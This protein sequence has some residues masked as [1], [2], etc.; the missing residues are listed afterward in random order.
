MFKRCGKTIDV[1]DSEWNGDIV[2]V[3]PEMTEEAGLQVYVGVYGVSEDGKRITPT[4]YAPLGAV[5]LGAEPDG[6]PST[7]PTLPVWAQLQAQ[8]GD[9]A[10]LKWEDGT[11]SIY[12]CIDIQPGYND[13]TVRY[14]DGTSAESVYDL[15]CYTCTDY[16]VIIVGF[17]RVETRRIEKCPKL[18][19]V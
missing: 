11:V 9:R 10:F 5:A 17:E 8:I 4:L 16:G 6:D 2:T 19:P 18:I 3:P 15:M 13:G 1:I 7:D 12:H 14:S